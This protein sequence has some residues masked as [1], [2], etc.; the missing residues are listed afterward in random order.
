MK[1]LIAL[2]SVLAYFSTVSGQNIK[3]Y[4][5][6]WWVDMK[7]NEIQ[8]LFYS[9][10][11]NF[12]KQQVS[13]DYPG[14]E[15][16]QTHSFENGKYIALDL[17]IRPETQ[18]GTVKIKFSGA[19]KPLD[20]P[21]KPRRQ[22]KGTAFANGVTSEDL[23]YL[24][25]P[26]RF[27]N[28]DPSND[29][30]PGMKDQSLN[31]DSLYFRHGGDL[32]GVKHHLDYLQDLGITAVWMMPVLKNDMPERSEHGYAF[33]DHYTI[34]PRLGD[35]KAYLELSDALHVRGMKL[36]Q[37]A[38]YN[39]I[40]LDHWIVQDSPAAD[41]VHPWPVYT[42]TN[43]RDQLYFD[44]HAAASQQKI[45]TDGW[46]TTHM[47]DLNQENPYVANFL[48]QHA[49]WCVEQFGIDGWRIDTYIYN[50]LNFMNRCNQALLDEY[51]K[52]SLFGETWVHGTANQAYFAKNI[53]ETPFKSN[54]PG[55]T[56]F[57]CMI[58]GIH[59][60][61]TEK[62]GWVEG[63]NRMY[64]TL[65][66]DFLYQNPM[67]NVI[68]LDNHDYSRIF[69]I[70]GENIAKQKIA[71]AW[72]LTCR[73]IPQLYYGTEILMKGF[74]N[75]DGWVRLDFPGGW[76]GDSKNAFTGTGL[77]KDEKEM[78]NYVKTLANFRKNSSALKTGKL[79]QYIPKDG[80]Y[81]YFRYNDKQTVMCIMNTNDNAQPVSI[82]DYPD[83]EKQFTKFRN[84][85]TGEIVTL[86]QLKNIPGWTMW[87]LEMI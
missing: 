52:L 67:Q 22:G 41:W 80:L 50:N 26:D 83:M 77:T 68:M 49:I 48:I 21:L 40:G 63:V 87:V 1:N 81:T 38:V 73:G 19:K 3:L 30:I 28:G 54:L 74:S 39:H 64:Q 86:D 43:Y 5:T 12:S 56:D 29:R 65:S 16:I 59:P 45:L 7:Y 57:Q 69:S 84:I 70:L 47:P 42:Q 82:H 71:V 62:F 31:R 46:F 6:N 18:P 58:Y 85:E 13:I 51:P 10:D 72:L 61:L 34:D 79:M 32:Q 75:P 20:W 15:L 78:Q 11:K 36:I 37:D 44:P 25:M 55:V 33:T 27:S 4:P 35:E 66:N 2:F 23:I 17:R 9:Q 53:F 24:L 8:L 60:A 76:E 14:I